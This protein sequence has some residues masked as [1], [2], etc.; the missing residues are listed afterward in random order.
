MYLPSEAKRWARVAPKS[1]PP[2]LGSEG[3]EA[4]VPSQLALNSEG[5]LSVRFL[6]DA[7]LDTADDDEEPATAVAPT[8]SDGVART[9]ASA[10]RRGTGA[11]GAPS[12]GA[13]AWTEAKQYAGAGHLLRPQPI[14]G[15][16]WADLSSPTE[17]PGE[18]ASMSPSELPLVRVEDL[19]GTLSETL[20]VRDSDVEIIDEESSVGNPSMP[21]PLEGIVDE[22]TS[23]SE[24]SA[25]AGRRV[26]VD[27]ETSVSEGSVPPRKGR[28]GGSS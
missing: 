7:D 21:L 26:I 1:A 9:G 4:G 12:G 13:A 24:G 20:S 22:E 3:E 8:L 18:T 6:S 23:V 5:A 17:A 28:S 27:E 11:G 25:S 14:P 2:F 16:P 10:V 19:E 15:A